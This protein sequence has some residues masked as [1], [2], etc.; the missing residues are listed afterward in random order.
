LSRAALVAMLEPLPYRLREQVID[1]VAAVAEAAPEIFADA[2][3][4]QSPELRDQ[5]IFV[6]GIRKLW[7]LVDGQFEL[8]SD[9]LTL[10]G[11]SDVERIRI[12]SIPIDRQSEL[13]TALRTLR[14]GLQRTLIEQ[15]IFDIV[16]ADSLASAVRALA[17]RSPDE[18]A[19]SLDE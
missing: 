8:V 17:A 18:S 3:I 13:F 10:L 15:Q 7:A 11:Q 6:A 9:S 2:E 16:R 4:E 19:R 12:G 1:Y 5:L 14:N